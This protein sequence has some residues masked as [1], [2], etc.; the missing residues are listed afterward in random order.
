MCP[1]ALN[2]KCF[3]RFL[4][5]R[6]S[7]TP[8]PGSRNRLKANY[9]QRQKRWRARSSG[10]EVQAHVAIKFA[11]VRPALVHLDVQEEVHR[12][13]EDRGQVLA[14]LLA[15]PLQRLAAL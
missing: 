13:V 2:T 10:I 9:I 4:P 5:V 1:S 8:G 11:P 12:T 3:I 14:R 6:G 15:D 7:D